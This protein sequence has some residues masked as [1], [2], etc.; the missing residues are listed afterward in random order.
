MCHRGCVGSKRGSYWKQFWAFSRTCWGR[1]WGACHHLLPPSWL[2]GRNNHHDRAVSL[3]SLTRVAVIGL[4]LK[5][6]NAVQTVLPYTVIFCCCSDNIELGP[7][8]IVGIFH[9]WKG[10]LHRFLWQIVLNIPQPMYKHINEE[11][12]EAQVN[13][14]GNLLLLLRGSHQKKVGKI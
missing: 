14:F 13:H 6:W 9:K 5:R 1:G 4:F 8:D 12:K 2:V 7:I 11:E 3:C 10:R